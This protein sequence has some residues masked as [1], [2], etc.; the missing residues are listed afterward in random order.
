MNQSSG[1][2][3][4]GADGSKKRKSAHADRTPAG[5]ALRA[6]TDDIA[7]TLKCTPAIAHSAL[8]RTGRDVALAVALILEEAH[9]EAATAAPAAAEMCV[10]VAEAAFSLRPT[11]DDIVTMTGTSPREAHEALEIM[12]HDSDVEAEQIR[13]ALRIIHDA[14][15][16]DREQLEEERGRAW[17][18]CLGPIG[19]AL[20]A[21]P[22]IAA[23]RF[24]YERA[25]IERWFEQGN[26]TSPLT[27][28]RLADLTL[29][30][31][32]PLGATIER[33]VLE[34]AARGFD[35]DFTLEMH[36]DYRERRQ[37]VLDGLHTEGGGGGGGGGGG[38]ARGTGPMMQYVQLPLQER[39]SL[40]GRPRY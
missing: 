28:L 20:M 19:H 25:H 14:R 7:R 6:S 18:E 13:G 16:E 2:G 5:I 24:V 11:T 35:D 26:D 15:E 17:I 34:R 10:P 9:D 40:G 31:I 22:V 3:G 4:S 23:D 38:F 8:E 39:P 37:V 30:S 36:D 33:T 1:G 32:H 29:R 21:D 27:N 12:R